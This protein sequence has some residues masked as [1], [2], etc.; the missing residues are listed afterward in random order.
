M[1]RKNRASHPLGQN[2]CI[3]CR[4]PGPG[5]EWLTFN[6]EVSQGPRGIEP[7]TVWSVTPTFLV[8]LIICPKCLF[9][10]KY[11][12]VREIFSHRES[13]SGLP[14]Y[15]DNCV[16][17][18]RR[19]PAGY[20]RPKRRNRL[21]CPNCW[22]RGCTVHTVYD[23]IPIPALALWWNTVTERIPENYQLPTKEKVITNGP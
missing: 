15:D 17:I 18:C 21:R 3:E 4:E 5:E 1:L 22:R 13:L 20:H 23:E 19:F 14:D 2:E 11:L 6:L 16:L 12:A 7:N 10:P 9:S 8:D